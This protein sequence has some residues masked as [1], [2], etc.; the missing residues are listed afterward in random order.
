MIRH[1]NKRLGSIG[2]G[3][4]WDHEEKPTEGLNRKENNSADFFEYTEPCL[5][6]QTMFL[7][8][9]EEYSKEYLIL[10]IFLTVSRDIY[11]HNNTAAV[12]DENYEIRSK[13]R[14]FTANLLSF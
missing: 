1:I 14:F 8:W 3:K 7:E 2:I 9:A 6:D 4:Y 11:L 5:R 12:Y 13:N 10:K